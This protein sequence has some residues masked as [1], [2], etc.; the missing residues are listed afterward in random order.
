MKLNWHPRTLE[1]CYIGAFL[2]G[3]SALRTCTG[4]S[5]LVLLT[6]VLV[7]SSAGALFGLA[8]ALAASLVRSFRRPKLS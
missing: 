2:F 3:A 1:T 8:L 5:L 6:V 7:L 4:T